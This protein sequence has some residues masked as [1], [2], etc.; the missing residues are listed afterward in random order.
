MEF[1]EPVQQRHLILLHF[2][3]Y[4]PIKMAGRGRGLTLPA[5]MTSGELKP[6]VTDTTDE[7]RG[8]SSKIDAAPAKQ[9]VTAPSAISAVAPSTAA[10]SATAPPTMP[11]K[12][13]A[14]PAIRPPTAPTAPNVNTGIHG[15]A[16]R[17]GVPSTAYGGYNPAG[18]NMFTANPQ[19]MNPMGM[20]LPFNPQMGMNMPSN[21]NMMMHAGGYPQHMQQPPAPMYPPPQF[22]PHMSMGNM[23]GHMHMNGGG[24]GGVIPAPAAPRAPPKATP[25]AAV[26]DPTNDVSCWSEHT[27]DDSRK[28]W[29]NRVTLVST[30]DKPFCLKSPE[31]RSIVPT[32]WKEYPS[33]DGGKPYYSNGTEST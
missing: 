28:Y 22:N 9:V 23:Q 5:W 26:I 29:Y 32:A 18:H 15:V 33:A 24:G 6:A 8:S 31:E 2:S 3:I 19:M 21:M 12:F 27:A 4:Q 14:P 30:Y 16:P 20:N 1:P 25:P 17:L 10:P 13:V 11:P 7:I